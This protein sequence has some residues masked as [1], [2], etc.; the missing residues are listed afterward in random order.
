M[1]KQTNNKYQHNYQPK[2]Q[3]KTTT[4]GS[5]RPPTPTKNNNLWL[6]N[7]QHQQKTTTYMAR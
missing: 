5:L 7:R 1:K 3:Q 6:A 4:Y 2:C